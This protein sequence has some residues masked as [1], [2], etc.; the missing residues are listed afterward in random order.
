[1]GF[2]DMNLDGLRENLDYWSVE[3]KKDEYLLEPQ[4]EQN[5][6][7]NNQELAYIH[8]LGYVVNHIDIKNREVWIHRAEREGST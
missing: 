4:D 6:F 1:M 5:A 7:L 3:P 8:K 2:Q